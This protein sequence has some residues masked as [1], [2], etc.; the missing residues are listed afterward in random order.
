MKNKESENWII[1]A[2]DDLEKSKIL[3]EKRKFD[4]A[5][6]YS[7][8]TIEKCLKATILKRKNILLR[9]HD[10]MALGREAKVTEQVL[11]K[12]K[13]LSGVYIESRYGFI[14]E[15]IPAKKFKEADVSD[16]IKISEEV[17]EWARKTM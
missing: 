8:Q 6:F 3:F 14:D 4:G 12:I 7:Q 13:S 5:A 2:K 9:T 17:L 16:F 1:Q 11:E 15:E 10:L